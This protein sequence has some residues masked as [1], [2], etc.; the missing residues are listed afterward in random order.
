VIRRVDEETELPLVDNGLQ[1]KW[2]QMGAV[3]G[4]ATG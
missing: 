3:R 2:G 4:V 1:T